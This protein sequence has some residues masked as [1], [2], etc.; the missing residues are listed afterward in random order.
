MTLDPITLVLVQKRLDHIARQMGWVMM[1]TARNPLFSQ[2]HDFSCF[3]TDGEGYM[4]SL[5]D[6]QPI[7]TGGGGLAARALLKA[8]EEDIM[9]YVTCTILLDFRGVDGTIKPHRRRGGCAQGPPSLSPR[10]SLGTRQPS[11]LSSS[12]AKCA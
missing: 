10:A 7:H 2:A 11:R 3:I 6:G 4:V 8:F 1:R 12:A 5:A 9:D